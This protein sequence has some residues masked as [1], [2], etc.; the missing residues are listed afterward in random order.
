MLKHYNL[1]NKK[2]LSNKFKRHPTTEMHQS[3]N[4][5][6][7]NPLPRPEIK[8]IDEIFSDDFIGKLNRPDYQR[9]YKWQERHVTDLLNDLRNDMF[10]YG[11]KGKYFL[12]TITTHKN[13]NQLD[14]VDGLQRLTTLYLIL[15]ALDEELMD[16]K[17]PKFFDQNNDESRFNVQQN[18]ETIK[19]WLKNREHERLNYLNHIKHH[20]FVGLNEVLTLDEA[21]QIFEGRNTKGKELKPHDLL[22]A[23]HYR[24]MH[25]D[26]NR[27]FR[28]NREYPQRKR[29]DFEKR[30]DR[31]INNWEKIDESDLHT[32]FQTLFRIRAWSDGNYDA[33][34]F[35]KELRQTFHG[36][37]LHVKSETPTPIHSFYLR[38]HDVLE[39][40]YFIIEELYNGEYFF[41]WTSNQKK[42]F[43]WFENEKNKDYFDFQCDVIKRF[44]TYRGKNRTGDQHCQAVLKA[45]LLLYKDRFGHTNREIDKKNYQKLFNFVYGERVA[46]YEKNG[47]NKNTPDHPITVKKMIRLIQESRVFEKMSHAFTLADFEKIP[48]KQTPWKKFK[49]YIYDKGGKENGK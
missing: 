32:I 16:K 12:G 20:C 22:K 24:K 38:L 28:R 47:G 30:E 11:E 23:F 2:E 8:S 33:W 36:L 49:D 48:L 4:T 39:L 40:H 46:S 19:S 1:D 5:P 13:N 7:T 6:S 43:I 25:L 35:S 26:N 14:I 34:E 44:F 45:L 9:P 15:C 42:K 29:K 21:F 17:T 10:K 37:D 3:S 41:K 31:A 27:G 18:F